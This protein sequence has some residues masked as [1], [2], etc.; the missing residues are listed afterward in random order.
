M[1]YLTPPPSPKR[2]GK[3]IDTSHVCWLLCHCRLF[4]MEG[5]Q[6]HT[7]PFPPVSLMLTHTNRRAY[8]TPNASADCHSGG[9][10]ICVATCLR[11]AC[12]KRSCANADEVV[13]LSDLWANCHPGVAFLDTLVW[14]FVCPLDWILYDAFPSLYPNM[15]F[16]SDLAVENIFLSTYLP[17]CEQFI[18][19][20]HGKL[21]TQS[22]FNFL[23][24]LEL[25]LSSVC[26]LLGYKRL[27]Y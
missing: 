25:K 4:C 2:Q 5:G 9:N 20:R 11:K 13:W 22:L 1:F 8:G 15:S 17:E 7:N 14:V 27:K 21:S 26:A 23:K 19:P 10:D 12:Q 18:T 6:W 16:L 3:S 24:M